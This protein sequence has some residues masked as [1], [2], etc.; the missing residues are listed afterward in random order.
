MNFVD[1]GQDGHF[2]VD[3]YANSMNCVIDFASQCGETGVEIDITH[4]AVEDFDYYG[5]HNCFDQVKFA[6]T[7]DSEQKMTDGLCGCMDDDSHPS[8]DALNYPYINNDFT[9]QGADD[10]QETIVGTDL[11]MILYTDS[12]QHGGKV[13]VQWQ[14]VAPTSASNTIEMARAL[15]TGDFPPSM[16]ID[17]GCA[18]RGE[19]DAFSTTIGTPIDAVDHA[20]FN[21]KKCVQCASGNDKA[22]I[23]PY[24]YDVANDSCGE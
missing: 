13:S 2:T 10:L 8:C 11:K 24:N 3:E 6:Y 18:G 22:A 4:L 16:A 9:P 15:M 23:G 14:C 17:Y 12:S 7:A 21:W 20:F 1:N 19:F 5:H